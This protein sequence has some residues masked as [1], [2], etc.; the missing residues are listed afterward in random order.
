MCNGGSLPT[1]V[2]ADLRW[3]KSKREKPDS[4]ACRSVSRS[5]T[6]VTT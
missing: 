1:P 6:L 5:G 3:R 2:A 4:A